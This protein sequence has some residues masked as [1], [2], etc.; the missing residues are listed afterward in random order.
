VSGADISKRLQETYE[1]IVFL[2][3]SFA[4]QNDVEGRMWLKHHKIIE[5]YRKNLHQFQE[6]QGKK[7]PVEL[8]KLQD[9]FVNFIKQTTRFYRSFIQRLVSH[10]RIKDLEWVVSK[11]RLTGVLVFLMH[12]SIRELKA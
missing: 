7:R 4:Q 1:T 3:F 10:F 5:Q 2:D 11:F 9:A 12:L 8:R 6:S